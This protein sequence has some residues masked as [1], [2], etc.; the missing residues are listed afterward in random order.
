MTAQTKKIILATI[1][2]VTFFAAY[3]AV[4][5]MIF[6]RMG[7]VTS[8]FISTILVGVTTGFIARYVFRQHLSLL[9][10]QEQTNRRL[11]NA[12]VKSERDE[13]LLR[14]IVA[15]VAEGLVITDGESNVLIINDAARELLGA[16][17]RP[18]IRL[19]DI[20]RDPQFHKVFSAVGAHGER[21]EAR[22]ETRASAQSQAGAQSRRILRLHAAPLRLSDNRADGGQIDGVVCAFTDVTKLEMLER[23]RQEF[24]SNVSHE[25]RT[26]LAAIT[27]YAETLLDGGIDDD[28]NSLRFLHTIQR[29]AE[30]MKAL[31]NDI[32][33][34]S[35][36]ESGAVSLSIE[37]LPLRRVVGDVFNGL[38][39]RAAKHGV[40]LHNQV[41]EDFY[42]DA[43]RRRLD[44]ILINLVDNAI[45]FNHPGGAVNV[46]AVDSD[47]SQTIK[48]SD[49][50]PGIPPEHLPRVFERF[51]RVDKAR[52]REAGGTGLGLAIVKHLALAHGGEA[53]VASEVGTGSEFAIK[54]PQR[55][56]GA[57]SPDQ[58][59]LATETVS[60]AAKH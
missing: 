39:H 26:P 10:E 8:H 35:A 11:Q 47:G 1:A 2:V 52:S 46:V 55:V 16:G 25:L 23:V 19:T 51:Y 54:L 45:K 20:S 42:V 18:V 29:N 14:S 57:L 17:Q 12:L 27:A 44:Q 49:T 41:A 30:R 13:S 36:I 48:V 59:H 43:D 28:E 22:V 33:E 3:E 15:S 53:Y 21:A 24:I 37:R 34:L 60:Y 7:V 4:K 50:G 58:P 32:S 56:A 6:P 9:G 40:S 5:T 31:V 38:S